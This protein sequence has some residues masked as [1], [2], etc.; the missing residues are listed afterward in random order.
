MSTETVS[1]H[2]DEQSTRGN[3][4][5]SQELTQ[6]QKHLYDAGEFYDSIKDDIKAENELREEKA[7][8]DQIKA[9][10]NENILDHNSNHNKKHN[11]N[12]KHNGPKN[13]DNSSN[14]SIAAPNGMQATQVQN[15][16][17]QIQMLLTM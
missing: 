4:F 12:N 11:N 15:G 17:Q 16:I 3:S 1:L 9:N 7:F 8:F 13:N 5:N 10:V 6:S 2:F 14:D